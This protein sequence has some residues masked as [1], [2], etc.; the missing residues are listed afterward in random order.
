MCKLYTADSF[1][2]RQRAQELFTELLQYVNDN[3]IQKFGEGF[4]VQAK[5]A[6]WISRLQ[7]FS[8]PNGS[9]VLAAVGTE[10]AGVGGLRNIGERMG[11]IKHFYVRP[12]FRRRGLGRKLLDNLLEQ[13]ISMGYTV[14]RL[15]TGWFM[16]AAQALYH[17]IG[18]KDVAPYPES[19]I[20]KEIQHLW[21]YM[22]KDLTA[23]T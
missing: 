11:E 1:E 12:Q 4:D 17:S 23:P 13:S 15:D 3:F 19:E 16:E 5:V 6:E 14:L 9:L 7:E 2:D 8:P 18:F 21:V 20:P 22:E 10:V